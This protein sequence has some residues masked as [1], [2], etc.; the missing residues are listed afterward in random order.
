MARQGRK[1]LDAARSDEAVVCYEEA[2]SL[3][4]RCL[5]ENGDDRAR[6]AAV[7]RRYWGVHYGL[8]LARSRLGRLA[9]FWEEG[10]NANLDQVRLQH[11]DRDLDAYFAI[12]WPFIRVPLVD[13][14]SVT[15]PGGEALLAAPSA[16]A[17]PLHLSA[18]LKCVRASYSLARARYCLAG[19]LFD[20]LGTAMDVRLQCRTGLGY[21]TA[22]LGRDTEAAEHFHWVMTQ[23]TGFWA[24]LSQ[25]MLS[26]LP[27]AAACNRTEEKG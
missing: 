13:G 7:L 26:A 16:L 27:N 5:A 20:E 19:Q 3:V 9:L 8:A 1:L 6:Q 24:A 18:D 10:E 23:S 15:P 22:C 11:A 21:V 17:F 12:L 25:Q 4:A 14:F 2:R